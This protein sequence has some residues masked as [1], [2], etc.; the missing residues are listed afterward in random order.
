L[1][2]EYKLN[3]ATFLTQVIDLSRLWGWRVAHFRPARTSQGWRTAVQADGA[4]FP[5]LVLVRDG[6]LLFAELKTDEGE[7]TESQRE[8]LL[9]LS[10]CVGP[11]RS[12]VW[13]PCLWDDIVETLK[14]E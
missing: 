4:G 2:K 6:V 14:D 3:E 7:L 9:A 11:Q 5:D 8:W 13:R 10:E 12:V 1:N